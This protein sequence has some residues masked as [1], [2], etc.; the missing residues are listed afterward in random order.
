[1]LLSFHVPAWT[2]HVTSRKYRC[3]KAENETS[4]CVNPFI[5]CNIDSF[6]YCKVD[7]TRE[8]HMGPALFL[9]C[10]QS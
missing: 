8:T 2:K 5:A 7:P 4:L 1:M 10:K 6:S 9:N 3:V